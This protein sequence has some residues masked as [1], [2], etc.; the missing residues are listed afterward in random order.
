MSLRALRR[1]CHPF[2]R[3][4]LSLFVFLAIVSGAAVAQVPVQVRPGQQLPSP[5]QAREMLQSQ[6]DMV[7][8]LRQRLQESGLTED[9]IRA[10]LRAA[11]YPENFLDQYLSGADTSLAVRPGARTLDAVTALGILSPQELDS[12]QLTDSAFAMSDSLRQ[13]LDS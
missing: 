10:R 9:Q 1:L 11:G 2:R 7:R 4:A 8:Q 6:P 12:L 13:V 3:T 5:D